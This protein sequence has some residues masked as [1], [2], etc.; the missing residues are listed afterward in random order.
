MD[1]TFG[2]G[3]FLGGVASAASAERANKRNI[4]LA[5]DQMAFQERMSNTAVQRRQKDLLAAG[6]NPILAGK[7]DASS[8]MGASASVQPIVPQG[9]SSALQLRQAK[10]DYDATK[11]ATR[12]KKIAN[13]FF[14]SMEPFHKKILETTS[15][16]LL[17]K[18]GTSAYQEEIA[19]MQHDVAR[20]DWRVRQA[21]QNRL[22]H[23]A[24]VGSSAFG[25]TMDYINEAKPLLQ[26]LS[27]I[28]GGGLVGAGLGSARALSKVR[29]DQ[30][31]KRL[32]GKG[33]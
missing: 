32:Y 16:D 15:Y 23:Q 7:F 26:P 12:E 17:N 28:I 6:I 21:T 19:K 30:Q 24:E 31:F 11:E 22:M 20:M 27:T 14:K 29:S 3:S 5:R 1:L 4:Q 13:D 25:K 18:E 9:I 33:L 2:L 10:A 8:P